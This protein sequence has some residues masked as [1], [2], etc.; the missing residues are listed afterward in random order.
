MPS[1]SKLL[2]LTCLLAFAG[3][4]QNARGPARA[5]TYTG[6][7]EPMGA[8]V[9]AINANNEKLPTL[10]AAHS[11]EATVVDERKKSHFLNGTGG[12]V[13]KR[14]IGF[15]LVGKKDIAGDV[16]E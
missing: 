8:V 13:Y 3:C 12:V 5:V 10:W 2:V 15:R 9:A 7:T 16:F 4:R 14:P 1:T 11:Y 6:P